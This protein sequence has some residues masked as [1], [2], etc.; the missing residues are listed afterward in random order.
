INEKAL[1]LGE[2]KC[3]L[4]VV[5][6]RPKKWLED[7]MAHKVKWARAFDTNGRRHSIMTSNMAES[8]NNV[9]RGI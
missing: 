3:L 4:G 6:E 5:G 9:L 2:I 8:F 7:H 1:F